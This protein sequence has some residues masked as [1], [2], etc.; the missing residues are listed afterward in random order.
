MKIALII[1]IVL[2][3]ISLYYNVK[4]ARIILRIEDILEEC[5]DI[6]DEKYTKM[7]EILAR[8]LFYDSPEI[9][10]VV[11]DIKETRD[12]LHKIALALYKNF[13]I[14]DEKIDDARQEK[15]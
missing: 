5:L 12:S 13:E 3:A 10:K 4:F 11:S 14:G 8:P 7:S 1:V 15:N 9:R 6:I 2:L